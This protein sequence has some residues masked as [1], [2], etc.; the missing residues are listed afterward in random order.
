MSL[1]HKQASIYRLQKYVSP[2]FFLSPSPCLLNC[3]FSF[4]FLYFSLLQC[5]SYSSSLCIATGGK[6][7]LT[8]AISYLL[9]SESHDVCGSLHSFFFFFKED[10]VSLP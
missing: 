10:L 4:H 1:S 6:I 2:V 3:F 5:S 9:A 7:C 8:T